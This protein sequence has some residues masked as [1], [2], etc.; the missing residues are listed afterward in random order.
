MLPA[1]P[2][3]MTTFGEMLSSRQPFSVSGRHPTRWRAL[4]TARSI[5]RHDGLI[6]D[7]NIVGVVVDR[8]GLDIVNAGVGD[9]DSERPSLCRI[10]VE[11]SHEFAR[12]RELHDLAWLG[13]IVIHRV[14]IAGDKVPIRRKHQNPGWKKPG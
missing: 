4:A 9:A 14:A 13:R 11:L 5:S 2:L 8:R 6:E 3:S 7:N 12:F 10:D 1:G